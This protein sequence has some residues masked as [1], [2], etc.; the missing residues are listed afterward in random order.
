MVVGML[1]LARVEGDAGRV[2]SVCLR[3]GNQMGYSLAAI[4]RKSAKE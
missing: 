4:R 3:E 2:V 1:R